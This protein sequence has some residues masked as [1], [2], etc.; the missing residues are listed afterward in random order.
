[1]LIGRF[2]ALI[3]GGINYEYERVVRKCEE[4]RH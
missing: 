3:N 2:I 1:M 4:Q